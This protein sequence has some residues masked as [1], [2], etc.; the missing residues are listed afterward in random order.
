MALILD[1]SFSTFPKE[2]SNPFVVLVNVEKDE[3]LAIELK[4]ILPS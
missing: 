1:S 3:Y 4:V 2:E